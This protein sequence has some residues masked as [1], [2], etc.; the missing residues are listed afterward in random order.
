MAVEQ[1]YFT[2]DE[3]LQYGRESYDGFMKKQQHIAEVCGEAVLRNG[4]V[5]EDV[6]LFLG[7]FLPYSPGV[8]IPGNPERSDARAYAKD[9]L[10]K[11]RESVGLVAV[12]IYSRDKI[13]AASAGIIRAKT[14]TS[15][16]GK[17]IHND[18]DR[19]GIGSHF[20]MRLTEIP[21]EP[22]HYNLRTIAS[23][24]LHVVNPQNGES[25]IL[26]VIYS[27]GQRKFGSYHPSGQ[28][29]KVLIGMAEIQ[30]SKLNNQS[31]DQF[32]LWTEEEVKRLRLQLELKD[33]ETIRS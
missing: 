27:N 21:V 30:D 7:S 33:K 6:D 23:A 26:S 12:A 13:T 22:P 10:E 32:A 5:T 29:T 20:V 4:G 24:Q 11:A 16:W 2:G 3:A 9:R 31:K 28:A 17:N 8:I 14:S 19:F 1:V 25:N 18:Y 15:N